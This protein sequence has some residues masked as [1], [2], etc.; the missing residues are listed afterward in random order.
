MPIR[1][2]LLIESGCFTLLP[3]RLGES[4]ALRDCT[5]LFASTWAKFRRGLSIEDVTDRQLYGKA[6][7]S[8]HSALNKQQFNCQTLAAITVMERFEIMFDPG[9]PLNW[10]AHRKGMITLMATRGPPTSGDEMDIILAL[11]NYLLIVCFPDSV[12]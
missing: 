10:S 2:F 4:T 11:D 6:L 3:A 1:D 9:R 7:R 5:A 8:L 12:L